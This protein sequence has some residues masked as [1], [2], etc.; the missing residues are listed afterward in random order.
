MYHYELLNNHYVVTIDGKR[1]LID[2]GCRS[3]FNMTGIPSILTIDGKTY[4]LGAKPSNMDLPE[5][6]ET[7]GAE[8]DGFI[9]MDIL[10][11]T[12]LTLRKDGT[13]EFAALPLKGKEVP[14]IVGTALTCPIQYEGKECRIIIDTGA[15]YGYGGFDVFRGRKPFRYKVKD[16]N[17]DLKIMFSDLYHIPFVFAGKEVIVDMGLNQALFFQL[18]MYESIGF[19]NVTELFEDTLVFDFQK[20]KLIVK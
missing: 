17:P 20:K 18:R 1:F 16:Y 14:L 19:T 11:Q 4:R 5:A 13:L 12:S 7:I 2:T 9:G 3:S 10:R 8:V 6:F 15:R